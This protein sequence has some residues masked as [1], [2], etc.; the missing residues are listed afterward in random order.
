MNDSDIAAGLPSGAAAVIAAIRSERAFQDRKRGPLTHP[1]RQLDIGA[2]LTVLRCELR[3]AEEAW[4]RHHPNSEPALLEILQ[5]IAV[6]V[7]CL[8]QHGVVSR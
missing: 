3:E 5:V 4:T 6:G 8:E 2:W 1:D 7:A